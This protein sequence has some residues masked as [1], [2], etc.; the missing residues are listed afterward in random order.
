MTESPSATHEYRTPEGTL[1]IT[2]AQN[3]IWIGVFAGKHGTQASVI[4]DRLG[5]VCGLALRGGV[6]PRKLI[7]CLVDTKHDRSMGDRNGH[8]SAYSIPDAIG[9][10]LRQELNA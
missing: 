8:H 3:P 1:H 6:P 10:A 5:A 2:V 7:D 4:G 9:L